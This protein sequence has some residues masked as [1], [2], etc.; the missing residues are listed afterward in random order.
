VYAFQMDNRADFNKAWS[1]FNSWSSFDESTAGSTCPP[2][3]S[4]GLGLTT[5]SRKSF[6]S[7]QGQVVECW[8]G[9]KGAPIYVW[10]MPSQDAFFFAV[11]ADGS[12]FKAL[13]TWWANYAVPADPP[14]A[15][16]NPQ[17]S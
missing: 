14:T 4:G 15:T 1:N 5:W 11:G 13:G 12:S 16:P 7:M 8:T 6:P 17:T 3:S 9:S 10:T 2:A